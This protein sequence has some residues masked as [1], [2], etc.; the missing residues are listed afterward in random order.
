LHVG[1]GEI[2]VVRH[3][4][5]E[6]SAAGRHTGR[7]DIPLTEAGEEQ[8]RGLTFRLNRDWEAVL[9]SPLQRAV[10]TARLAGFEPVV[11]DDLV[12]WDYGA[13]EGRTTAE[14]SADAPWSVWDQPLGETVTQLGGRVRRVL[15]TLPEGDVLVFGHGHCLRVLTAVYL[16]LPPVAGRHLR[17]DPARVGV[18]G[19]EHD[20]PAL[21]AWNL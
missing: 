4:E 7:T 5:T 19:H 9:S 12:E 18:L 13:A 10:E 20:W 3:G 8:A 14:L 21:K 6:W 17:L 1:V 11:D 15:D 16:G 2:W